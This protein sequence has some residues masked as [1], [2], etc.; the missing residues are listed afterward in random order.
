MLLFVF[1][2]FS[3]LLVSKMTVLD[4]REGD[5]LMTHRMK[6]LTSRS[7]SSLTTSHSR[8]TS[9]CLEPPCRVGTA[10]K[11]LLVSVSVN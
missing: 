9:D 4:F 3:E 10:G 5:A 8:I 6:L 7:V 2:P 11:A 1:L